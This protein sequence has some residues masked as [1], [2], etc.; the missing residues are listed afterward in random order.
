MDPSLSPSL[1]SNC[2]SPSASSS[3]V[4]SPVSTNFDD[5]MVMLAPI[6][7]CGNCKRSHI[8]CDS[9]RPCQNCLKHPSKAMTCR[10]A[11]PKPRGRPKGGSKAA[12][13]AIMMA[14][15]YQQQQQQLQQAR[16]QQQRYSQQGNIPRPRV[17]SLPLQYMPQPSW[18]PPQQQQQQQQQRQQQ[19]QLNVSNPPVDSTHILSRSSPASPATMGH[20]AIRSTRRP[21][22][23]T[24]HHPYAL[25]N[26][27]SPP[28][29][30]APMMPVQ[31]AIQNGETRAASCSASIASPFA[32]ASSASVS[33][34][35]SFS[36][37]SLTSIG[38]DVSHPLAGLTAAT[39]VPARSR[40]SL[41]ASRLL[42]QQLPVVGILQSSSSA[43][44]PPSAL[45]FTSTPLNIHSA[46]TTVAV[47]SSSQQWH[48]ALTSTHAPN[49]VKVETLDC[50]TEEIDLALAA[51]ELEDH[52]PDQSMARLLQRQLEVELELQLLQKR[53]QQLAQEQFQKQQTLNRLSWQQQ[54]QR[55][56]QQQQHHQQ[57]HQQQHERASIGP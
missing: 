55:F 5:A 40:K 48:Q 30:A 6:T 37:P 29:A 52:G 22:L 27:L 51:F 8:K 11:I 53:Q 16:R 2:S 12:A 54:Q 33:T 34:A 44:P 21:S 56:Q 1:P 14:R 9:G 15:L 20:R 47:D 18:H 35:L 39:M 26:P 31:F 36:T 19:Q 43:P 25:A 38:E 50:K 13:E 32:P 10:D 46:T 7:A 28:V 23:P 42:Q 49:P 41:E 57:Q 45:S 4:S 3:V 24:W 17:M